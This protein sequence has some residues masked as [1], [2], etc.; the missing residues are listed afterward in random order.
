MSYLCSVISLTAHNALHIIVQNLCYKMYLR[1]L[2]EGINVGSL[3]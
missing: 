2:L 3:S 1:L